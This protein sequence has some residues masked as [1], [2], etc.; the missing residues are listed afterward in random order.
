MNPRYLRGFAALL[1]GSALNHFGDRLLG[2]KTELFYGLGTFNFSWILDIF[3]V[4][5]LV[6]LAVAW[7]F[8]YGAWW[9]SY[10]P[11]LI[12][13]CLSYV[14]VYSSSDIPEG[15][16]LIPLGWWGFFVILTMESAAIGGIVGEVFIKKVYHRENRHL[17]GPQGIPPSLASRNEAADD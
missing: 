2:V 10:F 15:S 17:L 9:L 5:F 4:P 16:T 3:F 1:M 8:G 13:R 6:G 12:V 14:D 7:I 11:P